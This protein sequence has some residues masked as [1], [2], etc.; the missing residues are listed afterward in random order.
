MIKGSLRS[1]LLGSAVSVGLIA[2]AGTANAA[3]Y[4]FGEVTLQL[5]TTVSAGASMST[6]KTDHTLLPASNGG[7]KQVTTNN[8]NL[9]GFLVQTNADVVAGVNDGMSLLT[10][11]STIDG[12]IN[13]DDGRLNF[14]R[15]DL[16]SGIFKMT[17][18]ISAGFQNYKFFA[19]VSSYYDA[20]LSRDSS[21]NRT[22]LFDGKASAARDIKLLDFYGS[23]SYNV[24]DLPLNLRAGKQVI[25]WGEGTFMLNG[26]NSI[27]PI[28]VNAFRRPGAEVKEG[29]VPVWALDG[30][31]GLPY[32]LSLEA[33][34]Q[35]KWEPYQIDRSG[36]PFASSD[37]AQIGD[38]SFSFLTGSYGGQNCGATNSVAIAIA[39]AFPTNDIR[40]CGNYTGSNPFQQYQNYLNPIPIGQTEAIRLALQD[41][42]TVARDAD[43]RARN[44]GQW[45]V[46][47]R[48]YSEDLNNTEF[49]L[50]FM[51]YHSRLP[52]ASERVTS[53]PANTQFSPFVTGQN[54]SGTARGAAYS[55]CNFQ[56]T[57]DPSALYGL[58]IGLSAAAVAQMNQTIGTGTDPVLAAA[59]AIATDYYANVGTYNVVKSPTT[60]VVPG[61]DQSPFAG[62]IA[63]VDLTPYAQAVNFGFTGNPNVGPAASLIGIT[64]NPNSGLQAAIV[65]CA[66]VAM[67][68][69]RAVALG[70]PTLL[71]DGAEVLIAT[72]M[73]GSNALSLYLEYPEDIHMV[74]ASFNTTI[75][76]WGVQGEM[77]YRSN[78]PFQLD[79]D[80]ISIAA[81]NAGC[82]F[83]GILGATTFG[84]LQAG[85]IDTYGGIG[86]GT[87]GVGPSTHDFSGVVRSKMFTYD[88]GTTATYSNSNAFIS[89]TGADLGIL[90]TEVGLVYTPDVPSEGDFKKQQWGNVCTGGTDLPAGGFLALAPR[91]GCRPTAASWGYVLLGQLQYNNAFGTALTLS[92]T[93][94]FSHDV[95]GNT[96]AP[97]SNYRQGRKSVSLQLNGSLQGA[98]RGGISYTNFFGSNKYSDSVDRDFAA[99][100]LSY[101]F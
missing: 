88:I 48:W 21:Y 84:S 47:A 45:G 24:G 18:D 5:D 78:Q 32:N 36:T 89:M 82:T 22:P 56:G 74:G 23:A 86:C 9:P 33:F 79:T 73:L 90:V 96:P 101:A 7:P 15:G 52:I 53:N 65:N 60:G 8:V 50:Y 62:G 26:I 70:S 11:P 3:Q 37:V 97:I 17:N 66:L 69:S 71:N 87:M 58:P 42:S 92:P 31:I 19:R 1:L 72:P 34:Y 95:S 75:G 94:A 81:L 39:N 10:D 85:G 64:V 80:Q 77:S 76:T 59:T 61:L 12:S 55:G 38:N 83:N 49:G 28:D 16:T 35:L 4:N 20:V 2:T 91:S 63:G 46:A 25:S 14:S 68:S 27:N 44:S 54:G 6:A 40:S 51:N 98:W 41:S 43:R 100:N 13:T 67:Q 99:V 29:L 30:S 57:A 93:L